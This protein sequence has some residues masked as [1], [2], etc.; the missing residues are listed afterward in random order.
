MKFSKYSILV[1]YN[2][3]FRDIQKVCIKHKISIGIINYV[4]CDD[5]SY[6]KKCY[7]RIPSYGVMEI[8]KKDK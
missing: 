6:I 7:F 4:G 3:V 5:P 2:K 1:D 8:F